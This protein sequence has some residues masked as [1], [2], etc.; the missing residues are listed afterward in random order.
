MLDVAKEL[1][2]G[3]AVEAHLALEPEVDGIVSLKELSVL[4]LLHLLHQI[5]GLDDFVLLLVCLVSDLLEDSRVLDQSSLAR[6]GFD[7]RVI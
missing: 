3:V 2:L 5:Q 1:G 6:S 7:E 4:E